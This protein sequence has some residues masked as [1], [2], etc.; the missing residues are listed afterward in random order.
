MQNTLYWHYFTF[1]DR[2]SCV[3]TLSWPFSTSWPVYVKTRSHSVPTH[4]LTGVSTQCCWAC[5]NSV[6]SSR[7]ATCCTTR[8]I[9]FNRVWKCLHSKGDSLD[10]LPYALRLLLTACLSVQQDIKNK[11]LWSEINV[12]Y[13]SNSK[14]ICINTLSQDRACG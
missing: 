5:K 6:I 1:T 2:S 4:W 7:A 10:C 13:S 14:T 11:P 3:C 12:Y 8:Y 9:F